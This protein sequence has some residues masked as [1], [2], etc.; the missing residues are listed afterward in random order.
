MSGSITAQLPALVNLTQ[1]SVVGSSVQLD[2]IT[3]I[4]LI[5]MSGG[6]LSMLSVQTARTLVISQGP[7]ISLAVPN[8]TTLTGRFV[9]DHSGLTELSFL[10][11]LVSIAGDIELVGNPQLTH[12]SLP[13]LQTLGSGTIGQNP[14]LSPCDVKALEVQTGAVITFQGDT[15]GCP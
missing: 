12:I 3:S 5:Q 11:A 2:H 15:S 9:V 10:P 4:D 8:L 6:T 1:V 7:D 14:Q 13:S